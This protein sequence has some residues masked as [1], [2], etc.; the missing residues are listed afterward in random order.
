MRIT[1]LAEVVI[2]DT[3]WLAGFVEDRYTNALE[4]MLMVTAFLVSTDSSCRVVFA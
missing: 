4:L 2:R 1:I 3:I